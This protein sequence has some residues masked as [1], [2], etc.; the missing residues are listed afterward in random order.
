M[1]QTYRIDTFMG[2]DESVDENSLKSGYSADA[3]NMDTE[4]GNLTVAKG[5]VKAIE[6]PVPGGGDVRRLA[7]FRSAT[8]DQPLAFAGKNIY[9]FRDG[10][11]NLAYTYD[12]DGAEELDF[13]EVRIGAKDYLLIADGAGQMLKYDGESVAMFGSQEGQS[14]V[15]AHYPAMYK[16]R[17]FAAGEAEHPNRLYWSQL[18]GDERS[19]ENWG[20]AEASPNVEGGHT[21]IG[22][23]GGDP[24][25]A[26]KALSNQLLIFKKRSL[27]RLIGDKPSNFIVERI[28][29]KIP[30]MAHTALTCYGDAV[31]YLTR[32]GLYIFNGV[33]VQ[34]APDARCIRRLLR[35]A[36][37]ERC[38]GAAVGDRLYFAIREDGEDVLVEYDIIRRTYMIR[39]GF[40]IGDILAW[41]D[42]LYL[43]NEKRYLYRFGVGD[44][45]DGEP[46]TAWWRTP[47][48]DLYDKAGIKGLRELYLRS[49]PGEGDGA[50]IIETQTGGVTDTQ[51]VLLPPSETDTLE[52]PLK[53]EGRTFCLR[54][55]NEAGG[56]FSIRGGVE[57]LLERRERTR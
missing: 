2:I 48:T 40:G 34:P 10:V 39:R 47:M 8:G 51:R 21:E 13:E 56:R 54:F 12:G 22:D 28:D 4:D 26:L 46:V 42:S 37:M 14:D 9:A 35:K 41:D 57:L 24:I 6:L 30:R 5:Y 52:I 49:F 27:Y 11:W 1:V 19:I 38:K 33:T 31:Y 53:N 55:S 25:V 44:S 20:L 3:C 32:D 50:L 17:L 15:P 16:S 43:M 23:T 45:Y 29:A 7:L 36:D 18:P